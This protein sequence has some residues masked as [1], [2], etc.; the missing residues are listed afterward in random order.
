MNLER[1]L[2]DNLSD[3]VNSRYNVL[4]GPHKKKSYIKKNVISRVHFEC[5]STH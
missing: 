3:T 5:R 1:S 2:K 4:L